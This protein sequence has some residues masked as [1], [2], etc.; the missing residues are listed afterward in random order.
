[1]SKNGS[2]PQDTS[3]YH[4]KSEWVAGSV[5]VV[6]LMELQIELLRYTPNILHNCLGELL[7]D[8]Q[9]NAKTHA[10]VWF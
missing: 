3:Y 2:S 9:R 10:K 6:E 5:A 7:H 8:L 4:L 1:M